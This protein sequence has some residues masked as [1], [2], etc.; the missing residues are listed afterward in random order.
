M[1]LLGLGFYRYTSSF[2]NSAMASSRFIVTLSL[3]LFHISGIGYM[4]KLT[5]YSINNPLHSPVGGCP[6]TPRS[7][8]EYLHSL[9]AR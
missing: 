6:V 8:G 1:M 2:T 9:R 3:M 5:I 7:L 4:H